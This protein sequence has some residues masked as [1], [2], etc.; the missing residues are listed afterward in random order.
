MSCQARDRGIC[1]SRQLKQS[2]SC[3]S[4]TLGLLLRR[5]CASIACLALLCAAACWQPSHPTGNDFMGI[6]SIG[7]ILS[8][9]AKPR[10][11]LGRRGQKATAF[12]GR[13]KRQWRV[14]N[15]L[16]TELDSSPEQKE[17][18]DRLKE[19]LF[20]LQFV[21]EETMFALA[22]DVSRHSVNLSAWAGPR[23]RP[24]FRGEW[25][26]PRRLI[27]SSPSHNRSQGSRGL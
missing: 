22:K 14:C 25:G 5:D 19:P 2:W 10:M 17:A 11:A 18:H 13:A 16:P 7:P 4:V 3:V 20:D 1:S 26:R 15:E 21:I 12:E 27:R 9:I 24:F 6:A 8:K 23:A